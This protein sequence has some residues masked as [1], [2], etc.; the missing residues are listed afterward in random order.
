MRRE[1]ENFYIKQPSTLSEV[2]ASRLLT[3]EVWTAEDKLEELCRA[4]INIRIEILVYVNVNY[5]HL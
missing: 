1:Y 3:P 2:Y 4:Y 5:R